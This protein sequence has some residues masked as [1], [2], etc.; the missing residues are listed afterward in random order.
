MGKYIRYDKNRVKLGNEQVNTF[1][2]AIYFA[3]DGTR[4]D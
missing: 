2:G 4:D 1:G 3:V